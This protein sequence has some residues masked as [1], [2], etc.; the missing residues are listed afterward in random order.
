MNR[1]LVRFQ[2]AARGTCAAKARCSTGSQATAELLEPRTHFSVAR[3]AGGWTVVTPEADSRVI[4]VSSSTGDDG[5]TGRSPD[6]AVRSLAAGAGLVRADS[7]DQLLLKRG[8]VWH[9]TLGTWRKSGRSA[10]EPIL[11]GAYGAGDRPRLNTGTAGALRVSGGRDGGRIEHVSL[12]GLHFSAHARLPG[13]DFVASQGDTGIRLSGPADDVLIEDCRVEGYRDNISLSAVSGQVSDVALRRSIVVDAYSSDPAVH[14]QGLYASGVDGLVIEENLFDRNGWVPGVAGATMFNHNVYLQSNN[15]RVVVRGNVFARASSH[16]L[17]ARA[18]GRVED[19]LFLDNPIGMSFGL[20][21]GAAVKPGGVSGVVNGN[22]FLGAGTIDGGARGWALE[23]GNIRPGGA[24]LASNNVFAAGG[25]NARNPA[26]VIAPGSAITNPADAAG[27]NDLTVRGNVVYD[28][29]E[30]LRVAAGLEPGGLGAAGLNGLTVRSNDFQR[31][32]SRPVLHDARF[33]PAAERWAGNRYDPDTRLAGWQRNEEAGAQALTIAYDDPGRTAAS[34]LASLGGEASNDAMLDA[35]RGQSS[36]TWRAELTAGAAI[37]YARAGYAE[38]GL[39]RDWSPPIFPTAFVDMPESV[40]LPS[41]DAPLVFDVTYAAGE[42]GIDAS[43]VDG[44][45]LRVT[46]QRGF[47]A[48]AALAGVRQ[49]AGRV[50][51]TYSVAPPPGGWGRGNRG[52][53]TVVANPDQVRDGDGRAVEAAD[54]AEFKLAVDKPAPAPRPPPPDRPPTVKKVKLAAARGTAPL[55]LTV[56][57]SEDVS[58]SLAADDLFL[59][60]SDG[61][62]IDPSTTAISYDPARH[63]A[64]WTFPGFPGARPPAGLYRLVLPAWAITDA[65]GQLLDGNRDKTPGDDFAPA[66]PLKVG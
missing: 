60:A 7:A 40:R 21:N 14:A 2:P 1:L 9:E 50:I 24:T 58:A 33:G 8:D 26:I 61:S 31:I 48:P 64:T 62:R 45:D 13:P 44:G 54:L 41:G 57:F 30:G 46:G 11:I 38:A 4:Y 23:V 53:F 34:Y 10:Q 65:A 36:Q 29:F 42:M 17:Q 52:A 55:A 43:T 63:A 15:Q 5:N 3:D 47:D 6:R 12:I 51:A 16:G 20:V 37:A 19:N 66:K 27:V 39:P 25:P 56:L 22:V 18:G 35:M 28:W 59:L 32:G 49:D